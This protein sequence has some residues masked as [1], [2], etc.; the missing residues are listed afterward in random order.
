MGLRQGAF[1]HYFPKLTVAIGIPL[2]DGRASQGIKRR[3][4]IDD[5]PRMENHL[6][7]FRHFGGGARSSS[8]EEFTNSQKRSF[9]TW[10]QL[11]VA[12]CINL[13]YGTSGGNPP[14]HN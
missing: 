2:I 4:T 6:Y 1:G 10:R 11:W 13:A 3:S 12:V 8:P 14:G 9:S 7:R 5:D